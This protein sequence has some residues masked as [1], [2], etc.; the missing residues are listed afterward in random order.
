MSLSFRHRLYLCLMPCV[1]GFCPLGK[2]GPLGC[3][4]VSY[5][6]LAMGKRNKLSRGF[7]DLCVGTAEM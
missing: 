7:T 2:E 6:S 3:Y 1:T 5:M 4:D